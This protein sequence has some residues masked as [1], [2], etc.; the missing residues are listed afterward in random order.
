L[1]PCVVYGDCFND[2]LQ[3]VTKAEPASIF[4]N[5]TL[6]VVAVDVGKEAVCRLRPGAVPVER[7]EEV[8][9]EGSI[10]VGSVE[11]DVL[12]NFGEV[13]VKLLV[14]VGPADRSLSPRGRRG[15]SVGIFALGCKATRASD[16][17]A[18]G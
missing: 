17:H 14:D 8:V 15:C 16:E 7:G 12:A 5:R 6:D 9:N 11:G 4:V 3:N 10:V 2:R 18:D 1:F 13:A